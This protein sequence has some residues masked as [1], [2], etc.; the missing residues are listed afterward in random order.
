MI[1]I[2]SIKYEIQLITYDLQ[3]N[4]YVTYTIFYRS[5]ILL[6]E[7]Y[8]STAIFEYYFVYLLR[9]LNKREETTNSKHVLRRQQNLFKYKPHVKS[10]QRCWVPEGQMSCLRI[11]WNEFLSI[12][13]PEKCS[14]ENTSLEISLFI[15]AIISLV[16]FCSVVW[17]KVQLDPKSETFIRT[18]GAS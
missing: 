4:L 12:P 11:D 14:L 9:Y 5:S 17:S 15:I 2:S 10:S 6:L 18:N 1:N 8:Y 7:Y 16:I 13:I 3:L